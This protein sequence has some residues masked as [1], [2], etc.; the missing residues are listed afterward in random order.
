MTRAEDVG[1]GWVAGKRAANISWSAIARM[2]G[3]PEADLRRHHDPIYIGLDLS[4]GPDLC[5]PRDLVLAALKRLGLS[6]DEATII[7][8]LFMANG[9]RKRSV[10]LAAGI[11][12]GGAAYA[13]CADAKRSARRLGITFHTGPNGLALAPEGVARI[14]ELAGLPRG[15]P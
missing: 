11:V 8:R 2:A 14:S 1:S 15:R 7:T 12:G 4:R 3:C 9:A 5:A 13:A 6:K 10:E